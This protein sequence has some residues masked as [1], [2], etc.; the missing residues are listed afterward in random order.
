MGSAATTTAHPPVPRR[1]IIG[2]QPGC[3]KDAREEPALYHAPRIIVSP[4]QSTFP[5]ASLRVLSLLPTILRQLS[6]P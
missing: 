6:S 3:L 1:P 4:G 5:S 2:S